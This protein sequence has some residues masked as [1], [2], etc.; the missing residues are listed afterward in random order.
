MA[1][2]LFLFVPPCSWNVEEMAVA[3]AAILD[4]AQILQMEA[5]YTEQHDK[6]G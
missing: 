1:F 4:Y 6:R 2:I 3:K 5:I